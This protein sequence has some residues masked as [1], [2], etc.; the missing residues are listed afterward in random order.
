MPYMRAE[1]KARLTEHAVNQVGGVFF[2]MKRSMMMIAALGLMLAWFAP[3]TQARTV[4][5]Q[6]AAQDAAKEEADAYK[7]WYEANQVK[8]YP[9]AMELA[10]AY[11]EKFP[12]GTRSDYLKKWIVSTRGFLFNKAYQEKNVADMIRF[13]NEA[14]AAEPENLD[15]LYLLVVGIR[16]YEIFANPANY[17]HAAEASD[18]A[19]RAIKL[20][21]AGKIPAVIP[22]EKFNQNE[23][24]GFLHHTIAL[25]E[26]KNKNIDKA[27][28]AYKKA[29]SLDPKVP[30]YFLACG[31]LHQEK[32]LAAVKKYQEIPEADR[33]A[34]PPKAEVKA[35]LDEVNSQA[36]AVIDCWAHFM[37]LTAK[38]KK[39]Y[40]TVRPQ[41]EKAL[42]DLYKYRHPDSPDGLQKLIDQYSNPPAAAANG[43]PQKQS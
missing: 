16:T 10:K 19:G 15:Y 14:L 27:L 2:K 17:Q 34:D 38:D 24:L 3:M 11:L 13:G 20:I 6:P 43:A 5:P 29:S 8:D 21:E 37:G 9:K 28:E 25:T 41:V 18:Y 40:D 36:D 32:Y 12:T 30:A 22:K 35:A 4:S 39:G 31:S 33:S 42:T 1:G 26:Q 7:A 23:T